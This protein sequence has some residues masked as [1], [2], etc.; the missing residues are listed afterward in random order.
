MLVESLAGA[1]RRAQELEE[2]EQ[3]SGEVVAALRERVAHL[4]LQQ[5]YHQQG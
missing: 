2:A 4:E 3:A 1:A 5:Q